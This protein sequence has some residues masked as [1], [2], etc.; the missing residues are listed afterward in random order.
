MQ[1]RF[2]EHLTKKGMVSN[3][4][5]NIVDELNRA[6]YKSLKQRGVKVTKEA[7]DREFTNLL[8]LNHPDIFN[9]FV[10]E[11]KIQPSDFTKIFGREYNKESAGRLRRLAKTG[12]KIGAKGT[13][14]SLRPDEVERIEREEMERE[15]DR[16]ERNDGN[17]DHSK[18]G[19]R[20]NV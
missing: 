15:Q 9:K 5:K 19:K 17:N 20:R 16:I 13:M 18:T 6:S 2:M 11:Y 7:A 3:V 1:D 8:I 4:P 14:I 10:S 12:I